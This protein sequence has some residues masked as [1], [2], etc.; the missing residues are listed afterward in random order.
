MKECSKCKVSKDFSN[1]P[2][3]NRYKSGFNSICKICVNEIN[4]QYRNKNIESFKK[5]RKL[6]YENNIIIDRDDSSETFLG[7]TIWIKKII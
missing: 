4:R 2:K 6:Y 3:S 1:F 5:S 7:N